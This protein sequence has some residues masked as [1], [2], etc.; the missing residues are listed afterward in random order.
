MPDHKKNKRDSKDS[1]DI[2]RPL[3]NVFPFGNQTSRS[4][5]KHQTHTYSIPV[6][7]GFVEYLQ[8]LLTIT[9]ECQCAVS[10]AKTEAV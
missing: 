5:N 4:I 9:A 7:Q 6:F 3:R 2:K 10:S 8:R 1:G